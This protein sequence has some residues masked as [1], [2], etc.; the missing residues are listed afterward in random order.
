[1]LLAMP[2]IIETLQKKGFDFV[3]VP[4]LIQGEGTA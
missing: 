3:T 1:M 4:E 2:E